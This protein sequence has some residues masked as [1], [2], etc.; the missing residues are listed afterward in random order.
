MSLRRTSLTAAALVV[1]AML[2]AAGG[3]PPA[4]AEPTLAEERAFQAAVARVEPAVVRVEPLALSALTQ[5]RE[6][7]PGQGPSTGLVIAPNRVITTSFAVPDDLDAALVVLADGRRRAGSVRGRDRSRGLVLLGCDDLPAPVALEP[8]R[9]AELEPGQWAI[10]VGRGWTSA[11]A[12][13]AVGIVSAVHRAWGKAVQTDAAI[14][15]MNYGGPLLDVGGRVIGVLAPMPADTAGMAD[16]T[17]LYDAGI[18]FAIPWEDVVAVLPRL[19]QGEPL[20]PGV[21]GIGYRSRDA[22]NGEP[23]IASVQPDSPAA[24]AG[25]RPGDQLRAIDGKPVARIAD[26]RHAIE[27]R[28]AG[29]TITV[30]LVR[31][32]PDAGPT[33]LSL[34]ATL[35]AELP[36][37]RRGVLGLV[38]GDAA[39]PTGR[40]VAI[41]WV[42]PGGPADRAG[43]RPGDVAKTIAVG[44]DGAATPL[45]GRD[46]LAGLLA[47]V[48][49]GQGVRL[50]LDRE[51]AEATVEM[52]T[53]PQSGEVPAEGLS[54]VAIG[55]GPMAGPL[56]AARVVRLEAPELA[57]AAV[58]VLPPG[59]QPVPLIIW[60][61][62]PHGPVAESEALDWK[63]AAVRSG[64]AVMIPGSSG[65]NAWSRAD[66]AAVQRSLAALNT[67][68]PIDPARI[69]VAGRG[70]GAAFAWLVAERLGAAVRGVALVGS[71]VP[72]LARVAAATPERNWWVLLGPGSDPAASRGLEADRRRLDRAG[73]AVAL[74]P[75]EA[76]TGT[77]ADLLCR[78]VSLLGML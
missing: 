77:P 68:R 72:R 27:P 67:L 42:L 29:D 10:A 19:E 65:T 61:P 11:Q 26:A 71:G 1:A 16:G 15:P 39:E 63:A 17:E 28:Y 20:E 58:A 62:P 33:E 49:L 56:D 7:R 9:R 6:L 8:R 32:S 38:A 64:V 5:D 35:V 41:A 78:W 60:L 66:V 55:L 59:D 24:R 43:L 13:V 36:P 73:H 31:A 46:A 25:L 53:E 22:I 18:G 45:A 48:P 4:A 57:A 50:T 30:D 69:G 52:A 21:L 12:N 2:R 3:E 14:S 40:G 75:D 34:Q 23:V 37:W 44:N 47:G 76:A 54:S 70:A 51:E 74:L